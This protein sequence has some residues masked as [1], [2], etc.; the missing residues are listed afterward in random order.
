MLSSIQRLLLDNLI[1]NRLLESGPN[2]RSVHAVAHFLLVKC[3]TRARRLLFLLDDKFRLTAEGTLSLNSTL[4]FVE[5]RVLA[6]VLQDLFAVI[7]LAL[8]P[9]DVIAGLLILKSFE[10]LL[11]LT[12][13]LHKFALTCL[14]IQT[15]AGCA[16]SRS[17][18]GTWLQ[19]HGV[20]TRVERARVDH[21]S[22]VSR[23]KRSTLL[24]QNVRHLLEQ[25]AILSFNLSVPL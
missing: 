13:Y 14:P 22:R 1:D 24:L 21:A 12:R 4:F 23:E 8:P 9:L 7:F 5:Q 2:L 17:G 20:N 10:Y 11:V 6:N 16:R 19:R 25:Y 18:G 3:L 15:L